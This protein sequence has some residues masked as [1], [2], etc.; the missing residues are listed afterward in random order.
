MSSSNRK[1]V[2]DVRPE[3]NK[4]QSLSASEKKSWISTRFGSF[5]KFI[6]AIDSSSRDKALCDDE[7]PKK[8]V[9]STGVQKTDDKPQNPTKQSSTD[10]EDAPNVTGI[11]GSDQHEGKF[12]AIGRNF[13][14][15]VNSFG[16]KKEQLK[17][18]PKTVRSGSLQALD[19]RVIMAAHRTEA[20]S[21]N[22][23]IHISRNV[24]LM[25]VPLDTQQLK[26]DT[27]IL[28]ICDD[29]PQG[30]ERPVWRIE[31]Y[32]HLEKVHEGYA[33]SVYR[34]LCK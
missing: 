7:N 28:A 24:A 34:A 11:Q 21:K 17:Q 3:L 26:R 18:Q 5:F 12:A 15:F 14:C 29:L 22:N 20:S 10:G 4:C 16:R 2:A 6:S 30:M 13:R 19:T 23:M 32:T 33:S 8:E 27:N 9:A 31:D 1:Q 25:N